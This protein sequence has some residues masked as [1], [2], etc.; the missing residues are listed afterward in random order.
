MKKLIFLLPLF[1]FAKECYYNDGLYAYLKKDYQTAEKYF[2][3]ACDKNK[4]ALGCYS[5][6]RLTIDTKLQ[7]EY[8]EKA[9][10]LGLKL[11]CKK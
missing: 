3:L 4:N 9:C 2:K 11:A 6:S 7:K 5:F 8:Q 1:I 10:K